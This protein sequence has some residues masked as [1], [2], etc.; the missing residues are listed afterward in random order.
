VTNYYGPL[1]LVRSGITNVDQFAAN[2][3]T[4]VNAQLTFPGRNVYDATGMSRLAPFYDG[5][6]P[7]DVSNQANTYVSYYSV[8]EALATG[9][10]LAIRARYPGKSLDDWMRRVWKEHPDIDKPYTQEDLEHSLGE[11]TGVEFAHEIF[12]RYVRGTDD[13]DYTS[14][15]AQAGF[16]LRKRM[17]DQVWFGAPRVNVSEL[18]VFITGPALAG[19]PAYVAGLDRG[20]RIV[21]ID[22]KA[23]KE[24]K[25]WERLIKSHKPGDKSQLRVQGRAGDRIIQLTWQELPQIEI[26]PFEKAKMSLTPEIRAFRDSWL[27]SKAL[28]PL[29]VLSRVQ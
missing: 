2:L 13:L 19:S 27:G 20:D 14:L 11:T 1:V 6:I 23:I 9:I 18:G 25:D 22:G 12:A 28:R 21:L 7:N 15:L 3:S 26:V 24:C 16:L 17:P 5:V 10:D 4:A 29:P 8:G